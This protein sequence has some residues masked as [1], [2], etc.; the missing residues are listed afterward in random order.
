MNPDQSQVISVSTLLRGRVRSLLI[1]A[2]VGALAGAG[3]FFVRHQSLEKGI[4]TAKLSR[5]IWI[6]Y[7]N[8][9]LNP[10]GIPFPVVPSNPLDV[11]HFSRA[12]LDGADGRIQLDVRWNS[13]GMQM[14]FDPAK[15]EAEESLFAEAMGLIE[16]SERGYHD[17]TEAMLVEAIAEI[18]AVQVTGGGGMRGDMADLVR[19]RMSLESLSPP[20]WSEPLVVHNANAAGIREALPSLL[21]HV[22]VG[23]SLGIALF[24]VPILFERP[25]HPRD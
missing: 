19:F 11:G 13:I 14:Q 18:K 22:G 24:M 20:F 8:D 5:P 4:M 12:G 2:F 16:G 23:L 1:F 25:L 7:F 3:M 9:G 21:L 17:E 15:V 6:P 10:K